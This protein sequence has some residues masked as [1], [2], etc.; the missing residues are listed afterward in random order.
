MEPSTSAA[1]RRLRWYQFSL[2]TALI[3]MLLAALGCSWFAVKLRQ[4]Q[5]RQEVVDNFTKLGGVVRYD[6]DQDKAG[7]W[8][9]GSQPPGPVWLR[10]ILGDQ[11]FCDVYGV[12]IGRKIGD[13]DLEPL[14]CFT[15][16]QELRLSSPITDEGLK[17]V[18]KLRRLEI[19]VLRDS[20]I[21]DAGLQ[22]LAGLNKLRDV[23]LFGTKLTDAGLQHLVRLPALRSLGLSHNRI[24]DAG[25]RMLEG[26][27]QLKSLDLNHTEISDAGLD[28]LRGFQ[29]EWLMLHRTRVTGD[30]LRKLREFKRLD[31]LF[32]DDTQVTD[33]GLK[34][35]AVL[36][37]LKDLYV[38]DTG[39]LDA[40]IKLIQK[41]LPK[42]SVAKRKPE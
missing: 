16:L 37:A 19:L 12:G 15:Q 35:L 25:L 31:F 42:V 38:L 27:T 7:N 40:R 24:T 10:R 34:H 1:P 5:R 13:A 3:L 4:A 32:L 11:M 26:M 9:P 14:E 17:H 33:A 8:I 6:Y 29:L 2:R 39:R 21:T 20:P 23:G 36:P 30:G 22:H 28:C 41:A 18:G